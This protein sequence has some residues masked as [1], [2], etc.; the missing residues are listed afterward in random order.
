MAGLAVPITLEQLFVVV[1]QLSPED[2]RALLDEL[3]AERFDTA[4]A[5]GDRRR[6]VCPD[7][8]DAEIQAEIDEVRRQHEGRLRAAGD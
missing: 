7:L 6:G 1:R 5:E 2:R 4:M 8:T 3:L